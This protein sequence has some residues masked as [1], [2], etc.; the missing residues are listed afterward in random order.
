M[1]KPIFFL[2]FLDH[3]FPLD[4]VFKIIW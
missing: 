1:K 3:I 4:F 2:R